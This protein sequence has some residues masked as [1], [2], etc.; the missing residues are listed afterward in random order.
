MWACSHMYLNV[1]AC[2]FVMMFLRIYMDVC[3]YMSKIH[4]L[5]MW[6][7]MHIHVYQR[8]T[9]RSCYSHDE[10]LWMLPLSLLA[11]LPFLQWPSRTY[12]IRTSVTSLSSSSPPTLSI[13]AM[14][15]SR[16]FFRT[17]TKAVHSAQDT[18]FPNVHILNFLIPIKSLLTCPSVHLI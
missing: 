3:Q 6:V 11:K 8:W 14:L 5:N 13:L 4:R 16:V 9:F 10:I 17:F 1:C 7:Y 18:V 12:G 15:L 2:V